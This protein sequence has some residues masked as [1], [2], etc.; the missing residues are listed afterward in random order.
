M[1]DKLKVVEKFNDGRCI[2]KVSTKMGVKYTFVKGDDLFTLKDLNGDLTGIQFFDGYQIN[3]EGEVIIKV[4]KK[5]N[6]WL[7]VLGEFDLS[8]AMGSSKEVPGGPFNIGPYAKRY[9]EYKAPTKEVD[10]I[11]PQDLKY[12][13]GLVNSE[14]VLSVYPKYDFMSFGGEGTCVGGELFVCGSLRYGYIDTE[15]GKKITP[16]RFDVCDSFR[17]GRGL[18]KINNRYGFVDREKVMVDCD[19]KEQYA[20]NLSPSFFRATPFCDGVTCVVISPATHLTRA[21]KATL[22]RDGNYVGLV[23]SNKGKSYVKRNNINN[24]VN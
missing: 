18:V 23:N 15:T 6:E 1:S 12:N 19:D 11:V 16:I 10:D 20:H 4:F 17:E 8:D 22:D 5:P 9:Y 24:K 2:V 21:S 14:G 3:K 7:G 13:Y